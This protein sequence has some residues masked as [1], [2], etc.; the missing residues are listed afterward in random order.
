MQYKQQTSHQTIALTD[1]DSN[2]KLLEIEPSPVEQYHR[3]YY[4]DWLRVLAV[5]GVFL[6]H[7]ITIFNILYWHANES[8]GQALVAFG[9]EWGMALFFLL[10]GQA[11]GFRWVREQ[12]SNLSV[13]ESRA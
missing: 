10:A 11:P 2:D 12:Q 7:T 4:L 13:S 8:R 9:T 3:L 1:E 6:A 5:T